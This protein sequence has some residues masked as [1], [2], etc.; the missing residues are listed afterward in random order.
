MAAPPPSIA[1]PVLVPVS[2]LVDLT[3]LGVD[4]RPPSRRRIRAALPRGWV[5]EPDGLH[6]RRDLRL[7]FREAWILIVGLTVFGSVG[8][9]FLWG[10]MPRGWAGIGR[11]AMLLVVL[12]LVGGWVAPAI[13]RALLRG[14]RSPD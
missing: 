10:A 13:T 4:G 14:S 3:A 6:A 1:R 9:A 12:T 7:F 8:L 2:Q 11:L 5:L